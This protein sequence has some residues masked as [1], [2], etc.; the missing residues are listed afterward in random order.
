MMLHHGIDLKLTATEQTFYS[1]NVA[2]WRSSCKLTGGSPTTIFAGMMV[3]E[4]IFTRRKLGSGIIAVGC[5]AVAFGAIWA[6]TS[7]KR[8][9]LPPA[10]GTGEVTASTTS[11]QTAVGQSGLPLPRFVSLKAEKVNVR[12]G[13]SSDHDVAWVFQRKGLPVEIIAEFENWRRVRDSDGEEGWILQSMLSGKRTAVVAP[14][15]NGQPLTLQSSESD[16]SSVVARLEPGVLSQVKSCDGTWCE[17]DAAG[18]DGYA[19]Q[20]MLWG[21]YPGEM[22]E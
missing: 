13:P 16:A 5:L 1:P 19:K 3:L 11:A 6:I 2:V 12:K 18:Y 10:P 15:R 4:R 21:V 9:S 8:Q 22:V 17:L 14:W 20:D 7:G